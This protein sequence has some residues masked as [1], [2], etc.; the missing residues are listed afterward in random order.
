MKQIDKS[1]APALQNGLRI[2]EFAAR[3]ANGIAFNEI[4]RELEV[5][6]S[7]T[8]RLL[9]VLVSR[10][11][12]IK[13][14]DGKY[15]SGPRMTL[16]H[17]AV[18]LLARIRQALPS[19]LESLMNETSNTCLFIFW[20][21]VEMQCVDKR[22]HQGSVPMQEIGHVDPDLTGGPWGCLIYYSLS[23]DQ[24]VVAEKRIAR[25]APEFYRPVF[26]KWKKYFDAHGFYYDDQE[27]YPP[28]RRFAAPICA[29]DGNLV[30]SLALGGNSLTI[31]DSDVEIIG[32]ILKKHAARFAKSL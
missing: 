29:P 26:A 4:A 10:G 28:L 11:Y 12:L 30:G 14:T 5:S 23:K 1:I 13:K 25:F 17:T 9:S 3:T 27:F 31:P 6:K 20:T 24:R 16:L 7:T 19:V 22:T 18:P 32:G 15:A 21:G 2:I 8:S